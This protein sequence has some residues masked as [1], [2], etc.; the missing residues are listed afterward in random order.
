MTIQDDIRKDWEYLS[1]ARLHEIMARVYLYAALMGTGDSF[2]V[3]L[4]DSVAPPQAR[5]FVADKLRGL[6]KENVLKMEV[7]GGVN[8]I[9]EDLV[10][11]VLK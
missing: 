6:I 8:Y 10:E 9:T 7:V 1:E 3:S 11:V 5:K 4:T 2:H